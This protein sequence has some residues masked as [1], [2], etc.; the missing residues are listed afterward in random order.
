MLR[1]LS[2]RPQ[3]ADSHSLVRRTNSD[4]ASLKLGFAV[5]LHAIRPVATILGVFHSV[6][7]KLP[8]SQALAALA[9]LWQGSLGLAKP[10]P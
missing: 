1:L 2:H 6:H 7:L 4:A 9:F 10:R 3:T 5:R 8:E